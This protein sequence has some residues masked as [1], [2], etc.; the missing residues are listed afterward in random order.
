MEKNITLN[1]ITKIEGHAKLNLG[2]KDGQVTVC[3]LGASEGARYFEGLVVGRHFFEAH[4]MTSRICGICSSAHVVAAITAIENALGYKPSRQTL[5]LRAL[6]TLGERIRSH[7][8]HLYFLALPDYLGYESAIAMASKYKKQVKQALKMMKIGNKMVSVFGGRDLH[9]VSATPGGWLHY[10]SQDQLAELAK[11]LQGI[12]KDTIDTCKLFIGLKNPGFESQAKW[13]SLYDNDR[14]VVLEGSLVGPGENYAPENYRNFIKEHHEEYSSANFVV[15][16][17]HRYMVGALARLNNNYK[18]LS[19]D[20]KKMLD[21]SELKLPSLNPFYNNLAQAIELVHAVDHAI[22]IC[23]NLKISPEKPDKIP[24]KAG[25]GVG[26]I[27]APRGILFHEYAL[28]G[29][30]KI[31]SANIITPTA[32]NLYNMQEDIR[33]FVP[34]V[35][36][37]SKEKIVLEV[38]KLIRNYDPCFSCSAHFLEVDWKDDWEEK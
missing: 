35:M 2:I 26:A 28:D 13:F 9:P 34:N 19:S 16:Q 4:E 21:L 30:G 7:A 25:I 6:L 12:K 33:E 38:E 17:G 5:D 27:E 32:Q 37:K 11:E 24:L 18:H 22:Q 1:H 23:T 10:P 15:K 20:A 3:E 31:V 36:N 14:Y 29:E 8:T